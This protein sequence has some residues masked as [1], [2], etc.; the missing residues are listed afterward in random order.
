MQTMPPPADHEIAPRCGRHNAGRISVVVTGD[1]PSGTRV[2]TARCRRTVLFCR[3][4]RVTT[5]PHPRGDLRLPRRRR[6]QANTHIHK[7]HHHAFAAE[8]RA[9]GLMATGPLAPPRP[10]VCPLTHAYPV[11][12]PA[13]L[14]HRLQHRAAAQ[15]PAAMKAR[16]LPTSAPTQHSPQ[17]ELSPARRLHKVRPMRVQRE[18]PP[19]R[20]H[21]R[22]V[23][24]GCGF[25]V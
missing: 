14:K 15:P 23:G 11:A 12:A 6:T 22:R 17:H 10:P 24:G 5:A 7:T 1:R 16:S 13:S 9:T 25:G 19:T 18:R 4:A 21:S 20:C 8:S 3:S 2:A